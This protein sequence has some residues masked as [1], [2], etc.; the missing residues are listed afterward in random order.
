MPTNNASDPHCRPPT[1]SSAPVLG[2]RHGSRRRL[3]LVAHDNKNAICSPGP[4]STSTSLAQHDL[5]GTGTSPAGLIDA[6]SGC[7]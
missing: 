5:Y 6:S 7:R 2:P 1:H 3:A 4:P